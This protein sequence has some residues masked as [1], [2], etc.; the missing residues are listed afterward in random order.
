[1]KLELKISDKMSE[2]NSLLGNI[3]NRLIRIPKYLREKIGLSNNQ[4][5]NLKTKEGST[6]PLKVTKIY[7]DDIDNGNF[8]FVSSETYHKLYTESKQKVLPTE[9]ILIGCDPEFFVVDRKSGKNVSASHF[10][11][12]NGQV[13]S[14]CGLAEIRPHPSNTVDGLLMNTR[15]LLAQA[16]EVLCERT[17][18]KNKDVYM[19]GASV[20]NKAAAGFHIHFGLP[21]EALVENNMITEALRHRMVTVL[22]YYVGIL[23]I[24]P[25]GKEDS[26]RRAHESGQ[27]G[28]P[29]DFRYD[30]L[31]FEYRV[32]GGHLLRH[33]VL[34]RG[35]FAISKVVMTDMLSRIKMASSNFKNVDLLKNYESMR[36]LYPNLPDRSD[37]YYTIT[38]KE[39]EGA[40]ELVPYI[41][42]DL[43]Q[44]ESF[45]EN[46]TAIEDYLH[47]IEFYASKGHKFPEDIAR[48]WR[49]INEVQPEQMAVHQSPSQTSTYT[50]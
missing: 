15:A 22:D 35:L 17:L 36:L 27:Y 40:L 41:K 19:V 38:S 14:D 5:I 26:M 30:Y 34:T 11:Q 18:F 28:K 33:P 29:G 32:P 47:Y 9:D 45:V 25:E 23:S 1:M 46:R 8:A 50:C 39:I 6:L 13:G 43:E 4:Y 12:Y 10:F 20:C 21:S 37:V 3:E 42:K 2:K 49:L 7:I 24:I 16:H 31:T 48:N 44:M